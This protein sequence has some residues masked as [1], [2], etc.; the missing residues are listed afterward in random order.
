[1]VL[2]EFGLSRPDLVITELFDELAR[3][4]AAARSTTASDRAGELNQLAIEGHHSV[5]PLQVVGNMRSHINLLAHEGVLQGEVKSIFEFLFT[6]SHQVIKAP[7][8]L[9]C[10]EWSLPMLAHLLCD[11]V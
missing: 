6:R 1:V 11:L 5:A 9:R 2:P 7:R 4:T 8:V 3:H 10:L